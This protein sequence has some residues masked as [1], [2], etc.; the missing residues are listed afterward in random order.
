MASDTSR[1]R[2]P[3]GLPWP[4]PR[5]AVD[6]AEQLPWAFGHVPAPRR[7]EGE[8][9]PVHLGERDPDSLVC[10]MLGGPWESERANLQEGDYQLL[11]PHGAPIAGA[12][13]IERKSMADLRGSLSRGHDRLMAEMER[14]AP[15]THPVLI[16]EAP[17]EV[18]LG[19]M[20]GAVRALEYAR[21]ALVGAS[22]VMA[23]ARLRSARGIVRDAAEWVAGELGHAPADASRPGRVTV[24]SLLG[25]TLSILSDHRIPALFLPSRAWAE[26]A[27]AW[28]ARRVWRRWLLEHPECLAEERARLAL[29][30]IDAVR[31]GDEPTQ[32]PVSAAH[33]AEAGGM[34]WSTSEAQRRREAKRKTA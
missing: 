13:C 28:L 16:V 29:A 32:Q 3:D 26:Y 6:T 17:I 2:A 4:S 30:A 27:A 34:P 18:L 24:Q 10:T 7:R 11:G 5:V 12:L 15:Y 14:M 33:V 1:A 19:D 31:N 21:R 8:R 23:G 25:S 9:G 20:S 22:N